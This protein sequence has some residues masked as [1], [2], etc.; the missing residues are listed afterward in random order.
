MLAEVQA[1]NLPQAPLGAVAGNRAP[2]PSR[3]SEADPYAIVVA[4]NK[5]QDEGSLD[6]LATTRGPDEVAPE[7][8]TLDRRRQLLRR[9]DAC[10]RGCA[11]AAAPCVRQRCRSARGTRAVA[12]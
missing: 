9:T 5:L 4:G 11:A 8:Q 2:D 3:R 12:C 10:G 1:G 6:E 7:A